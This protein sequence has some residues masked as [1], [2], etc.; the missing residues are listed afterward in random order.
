MLKALCSFDEALRVLWPN[1]HTCGDAV[2]S[3]ASHLTTST[4]DFCGLGFLAEIF[5]IIKY[6]AAKSK[7]LSRKIV[8]YLQVYKLLEFPSVYILRHRIGAQCPGMQESKLY[9]GFSGRNILL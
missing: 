9:P 2:A 3:S 5:L 1:F 4:W 6:V 7:N 8:V